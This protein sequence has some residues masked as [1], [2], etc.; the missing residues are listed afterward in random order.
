MT[1]RDG[2]DA[3]SGRGMCR[4]RPRVPAAR[5]PAAVWRRLPRA[6]TDVW[7]WQMRAACRG[8]DSAV[9]FHPDRERGPARA[10]REQR[11]KQIC[12]SCPVLAQC[13][14]HALAV[15]E[16]YG[17]W[18][19][20]S[21]AD[22]VAL[23]GPNDK[24]LRVA[25][26]A[27]M[28][29]PLEPAQSP[30]PAR[31]NRAGSANVARAVGVT[32]TAG[33]VTVRVAARHHPG[34]RSTPA[35]AV[36]AVRRALSVIHSSQGELPQQLTVAEVAAMLRVSRATVY[37]LVHAGHLPGTRVGRSIRIA[38]DAVEQYRRDAAMGGT[39]NT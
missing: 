25:A 2:H 38:R 30:G 6:V 27:W 34:T 4:G 24:A 12:A 33:V 3:Q 11:A 32:T 26:P 5:T 1:P 28:R 9:F 36:V 13:R 8:L 18:G 10:A 7:D 15:G 39:D 20:L 21:E 14:R 19:G 16:P 23:A 35:A 17:I 22:R 29:L 31:N 37:R